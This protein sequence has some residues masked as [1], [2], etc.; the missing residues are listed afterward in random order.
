M[1]KDLSMLPLAIG[2]MPHMDTRAALRLIKDT[3]PQ[4]P[5]WPQLPYRS[6][7]EAM[8]NQ[9]TFPYTKRG[10]VTEGEKSLVFN[11]SLETRQEYLADVS[12]RYQAIIDG[13]PDDL[14][15][16]ALPQEAALG[17]Y[18]FLQ[19]LK[20]GELDDAAYLKGQV[21]GPVTLAMQINGPDQKAASYHPDLREIIVKGTALQ[22]FWQTRT[23]S[24]FG[25]PVILFIDEPGLFRV[26]RRSSASLDKGQI[27]KDLDE[28]VAAIHAA[29][30]MAGI[31]VCASTDWSLIL[32]TQTDILSFDAHGYFKSLT[33][34][35]EPIN[36]FLTRGGI[37]AWGLIPTT[38]E[39]FQLTAADLKVR[40][41][42]F[43]DILAGKGVPKELLL[44]QSLFSPSCGVGNC[45]VELAEKVYYLTAETAM[46]IKQG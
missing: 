17:F 10:L 30:G 2:S 18:D 28:V 31:H 22:A 32:A 34:Y 42:E 33:V 9:Y 14:S 38:N 24:K 11:A 45:P 13:T 15:D 6:A 29:G 16:F 35:P 46:L 36:A 3:M 25:K 5:H 40:F 8:V 12:R 41:N 37:L 44:R 27:I 43:V 7:Q 20:N 19:E 26:S 1:K 21:C 23:L 39:V 4:L